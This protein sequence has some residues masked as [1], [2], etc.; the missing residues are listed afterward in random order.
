MSLTHETQGKDY[1][2]HNP[3]LLYN[4]YCIHSRV[5]L[6]LQVQTAETAAS[7]AS[8][9]AGNDTALLDL[10]QTNSNS[11]EGQSTSFDVLELMRQRLPVYAVNC[12]LAAGYDVIEVISNMD[13]SENPGNTIK[14]IENFIKKISQVIVNM[15]P[16][17]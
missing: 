5:R 1:N 13:V 9:Q 3:R 16:L 8:S 6:Q 14:K 17:H 15:F 12:L 11:S 4:D 7:Q 10:P 2:P